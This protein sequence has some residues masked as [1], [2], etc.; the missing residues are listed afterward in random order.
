MMQGLAGP[1]TGFGFYSSQ[2][3][4]I[5]KQKNDIYQL[6]NHSIQKLLKVKGNGMDCC[7]FW[8]DHKGRLEVHQIQGSGNKE[9][10]WKAFSDTL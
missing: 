5:F 3:L 6:M 9:I 2:S 7:M 1:A 4:K 10:R 8:K